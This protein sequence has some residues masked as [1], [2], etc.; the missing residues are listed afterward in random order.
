MEGHYKRRD[1]KFVFLR[2][3]LLLWF[4]FNK[5][6]AFVFAMLKEAWIEEFLIFAN[7]DTNVD[8]KIARGEWGK[9]FFNPV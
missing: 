2:N 4:L 5:S 3:V 7:N 6:I 9:A 1:H 8:L